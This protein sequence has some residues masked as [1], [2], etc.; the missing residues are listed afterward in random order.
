MNELAEPPLGRPDRLRK[1]AGRMSSWQLQWRRRRRLGA[2]S[3]SSCCRLPSRR[4]SAP[5]IAM[6]ISALADEW[7]APAKQMSIAGQLRA[8]AT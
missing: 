2:T 5:R 7:L 8:S 3:S 4:R 6:A 1:R